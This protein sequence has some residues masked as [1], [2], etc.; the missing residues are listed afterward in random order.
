MQHWI[1][2][3]GHV[4]VERN[5]RAHDQAKLGREM[6][7]VKVGQSGG[8]DAIDVDRESTRVPPHFGD[9]VADPPD[10]EWS[11]VPDTGGEV[12]MLRE[13][14]PPLHRREG[15]TVYNKTRPRHT[16]TG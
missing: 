10:I 9:F 15:K 3:P 12:C 8:S 14:T 6:N 13:R 1:H 16:G 11:A 7:P 5:Q 2:I 4:L